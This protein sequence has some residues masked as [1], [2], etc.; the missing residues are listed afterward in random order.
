MLRR[1]YHNLK[2]F[3]EAAPG[4]VNGA[5]LY[6]RAHLE[7]TFQ[8]AIGTPG[9]SFAID[10]A[11]KMGL[12]L[13]VIEEAK[14]IVGSD[15]VN[16]DKYLSDIARDRK[17]WANKRLNIREKENKLDNLLSKYRGILN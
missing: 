6:D 2:S 5:M 4:F 16:L 11:H 12:P 15:Y 14:N 9:S 17:Y 3:A 7:P 13:E 1:R 8:L 10:I